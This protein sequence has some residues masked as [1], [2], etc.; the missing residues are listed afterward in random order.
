MEKDIKKQIFTLVY[1][2]ALIAVVAGAVQLLYNAI[3]MF[4]YGY[5]G[6][7]KLQLP[8][9]IVV[10]LTAIFAI[11]FDVLEIK[12]ICTKNDKTKKILFIINTVLV[13]MVVLALI[14]CKILFMTNRK[15]QFGQL[16][17]WIYDGDTQ[18]A[19]YQ[20]VISILIT[21]LVYMAIIIAMHI[22]KKI[23]DKK[24]NKN[25][26]TVAKLETT[27]NENTAK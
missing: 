27:P 14:A 10:L 11:T 21:Q 15:H 7:E 24:N 5:N 1:A 4:I 22:A 16:P 20:G 25:D 12:S 9:A 3:T 2:V 13:G 23:A 19:L 26:K 18:F 6:Y 8:I 17:H